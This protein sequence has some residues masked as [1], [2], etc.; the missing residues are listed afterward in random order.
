MPPVISHVVDVAELLDALRHQVGEAG[1]LDARGGRSHTETEPIQQAAANLE[2]LEVRIFP[3]HN[4]LNDI[5][6]IPE[7]CISG[8]IDAPPDCRVGIFEQ[9]CEADYPGN[10]GVHRARG[11][12]QLLAAVLIRPYARY[13]ATSSALNSK[14]R[15]SR[16]ES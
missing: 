11:D 9:D 5:V 8:N 16:P 1:F 15:P 3:A 6:K 13:A 2:L 10:H 14:P 12:G 7:R 4:R